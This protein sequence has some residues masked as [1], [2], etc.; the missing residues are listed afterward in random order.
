MKTYTYDDES[1]MSTSS[2]STFISSNPGTGYLTIRAYAASKALP[3]MGVKII[4]YKVI[5]DKKVIFFE[6]KT[7]E[8]GIINNIK[9]PSP[10]ANTNDLEIPI[11]TNYDIEA[12]YEPDKLNKKYSVNMYDGIYVIQNIIIVPKNVGDFFGN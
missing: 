1:F 5:D 7:N 12:I 2:Y 8:S 6:G 10:K 11:R 4:V 3:I 9:L